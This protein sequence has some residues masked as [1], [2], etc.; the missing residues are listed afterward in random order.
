V[1]EELDVTCAKVQENVNQ[2]KN[3]VNGAK[4]KNT[5]LKENPPK[6]VPKR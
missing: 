3:R 1:V 6:K 2:Q 4:V 5:V